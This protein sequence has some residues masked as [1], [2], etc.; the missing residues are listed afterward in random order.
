MV[1]H[2]QTD[3]GIDGGDTDTIAAISTPAGVGGIGIVRLSGPNSVAIAARLS[4]SVPPPRNAG[5]RIF[6]DGEGGEIDRGVLLIFPAPNSYTGEDVVEFQCHG[7]PVVLGM[8]L[9]RVLDLGARTAEPGEFTRRAFLNSKMDLA[10]AEAVVDLINSSTEAAARCALRSLKGD[11]SDKVARIMD[12]LQNLRI[13]VESAIDFPDE[14]I[15]F[16]ED[17]QLITSVDG[18]RSELADLLDAAERGKVMREGIEVVIAGLPNAG[19]SSLLNQLAGL[20]RSIVTPY[21]GTT[22]DTV[23]LVVDI[24]GLAVRITDTAGLRVSDNPVEQEGISRAWQSISDADLVLYLI[25]ITQDIIDTDRGNLGKIEESKLLIVWNKIDLDD[26]FVPSPTGCQANEVTISAKNALGIDAIRSHIRKFAGITAS[27]EGMFLARRRHL[28]AIENSLR[29]VV[30]AH[31]ALS[32][33][34]SGELAAQ[35]LRD[36]MD[37]LGKIVGTRSADELLGE[38]FASFCIGK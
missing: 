4:S 23:D 6:Y 34:K 37:E 12:Q 19:K 32:E 11:F 14:E 33:N 26:S 21:A 10:Q 1:Y 2:P 25:D 9:A 27:D 20:E 5:Y 38:I 8:L 15:D 31:T 18:I 36:A 3:R 29:F 7:G 24:E 17:Q 35:D 30:N 16:L 13:Y 28:E 22:R